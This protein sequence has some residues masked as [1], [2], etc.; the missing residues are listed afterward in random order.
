[1]REEGYLIAESK[2]GGCSRLGKICGMTHDC[3]NRFLER[4]NYTPQDLFNE[5]KGQI[6]LIG[7]IKQIIE[8]RYEIQWQL[9][10]Q[11]AKEFITEKFQQ[12]MVLAV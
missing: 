5:I 6:N 9:Y 4:E 11:V 8:S 3:V 7:R 2:Y 10:I 12:K 1:V